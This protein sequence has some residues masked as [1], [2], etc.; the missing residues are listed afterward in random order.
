MVSTPKSLLTI[1]LLLVASAS[2]AGGEIYCCQSAQ[3]RSVCAD[4]LPDQC[5]G[6]AYR[7][8]DSGGNVIREVGQA[9]TTEEKQ[10]RVAEEKRRK[11]QEEA[12]REQRRRDQALL[13]T[14]ATVQDIDI[15]QRKA[16]NDLNYAISAAQARI[17][18]AEVKHKKLL[19]EA[20]F[21]RKKG[22]PPE[23]ARDLRS[24]EYEIRIEQDLID[25]KK[26]DFDTVR[27]KYDADRQ[28]YIELTRRPSPAVPPA[29]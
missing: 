15:S 28:R 17:D 26:R 19:N 7:I 5:R 12:V 11:Q 29:R 9:L 24:V 25:A 4:T 23:L 8:L 22:L 10:A 14:Y 1:A 3:G 13:D 18:V 6:R 16:E 2:H 20:E 21:Y 27:A